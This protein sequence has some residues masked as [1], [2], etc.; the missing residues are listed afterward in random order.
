MERQT[1]NL[2]RDDVEPVEWPAPVWTNGKI[3]W[4]ALL[5]GDECAAYRGLLERIARLHTSGNR[6]SSRNR[7]DL[8]RTTDV[9]PPEGY[10]YWERG[11]RLRTGF[12]AF[13]YRL[14]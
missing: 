13:A 3:Y 9:M 7:L 6:M 10:S 8:I 4:P 12:L 11:L 1:R 2:A 5:S 14:P